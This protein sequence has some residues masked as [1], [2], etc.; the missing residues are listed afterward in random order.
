M[1]LCKYQLLT[2]YLSFLAERQIM[3]GIN[4]NL[5]NPYIR[6]A[7]RSVFKLGTQI[8][9]RTIFDYELIYV[10]KGS[11]LLNFN[12]KDYICREGQFV[13]LRPGIP[14]SFNC[15]FEELSQPHIH[16]DLIYSDLSPEIPVSFKDADKFTSKERSFLQ[17]DLFEDYPKAPFV[18]FKNP[19]KVLKLF[20]EIIDS[21]N[22]VTNLQNKALL[23]QLVGML[24]SENFSHCFSNRAVSLQNR[25]FD[26]FEQIKDF[27]DAGQANSMSLTDF[28]NQFSYDKY[29]LERQFKNRYNVGLITYRNQHR[30]D[31]ACKMLQNNSVSAVSEKLGFSSIYTFSRAFKNKYGLSPTEYKYKNSI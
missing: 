6:V 16:F 12:G 21:F 4:I 27:I 29:Y 20:F 25:K 15:C 1:L 22:G 5:I 3:K 8:N 30:M 26:V 17:N 23:T 19:K 7:M 11:F 31:K 18:I 9:R 28:E 10:E 2:N 14:H 24:I 13:L